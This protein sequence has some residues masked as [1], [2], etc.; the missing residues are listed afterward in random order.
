MIINNALLNGRFVNIKATNGVI[1]EI[2]DK[3]T[4]KGFDAGGNIVIPGFI[5][6]HTHGCV[7]LDTMDADFKEMCEFYAAN[8]I[9]SFLPTTMTMDNASLKRVTQAKTDFHGAN[10]LGFHFEG[11]Y[12]SRSKKGAQNEL[13]IRNPSI[14]E[15]EQ[16]DRVKMITLAPELEGSMD[17]IRAASKK[18]VVSIGHT[19]CDCQTALKAIDN[20]ALCLTHTFNAMPPLLHRNAGPIGAAVERRI[21]AQLICDGL[22]VSKQAVIALYRMLGADRVVLISDSIRCAGL[23]DGEYESGG[24]KVILKNNSARLTDG[25]IA[26]SCATLRDCVKKAV[27][28]GIPFEAAVRSATLTPAELLGVRKGKIA[29]GYDADLLIID[30]DFNIKAAFIGGEKF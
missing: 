23:A 18:C 19:D 15:F 24:L 22:H 25:T 8:G 28:F 1:S 9:T 11:P 3:V 16:L 13:Y 7:G 27:E 5:D 29:E 30:G 12:I 10:I 6:V 21:Y 2:T 14:S 17:F 4:E 26:G 20:G